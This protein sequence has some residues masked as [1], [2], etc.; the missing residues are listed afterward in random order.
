MNI[1]KQAI[2]NYTKGKE[3]D[4]KTDIFQELNIDSL[5]F[6]KIIVE[7]ELLIGKEIPPELLINDYWRNID[8]IY[9]TIQ[10]PLFENEIR[11]S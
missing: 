3:I 1:T 7:I 2:K 10:N 4:D 9:V 11:E 6:V 5:E 8:L